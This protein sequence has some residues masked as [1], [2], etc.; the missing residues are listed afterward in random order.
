MNAR[1]RGA[2]APW[3][4]GW[5]ANLVAGVTPAC[6]REGRAHPA[7]AQD[8]HLTGP[9]P[10][11]E[12]AWS[13]ALLERATAIRTALASIEPLLRSLAQRQFEEGFAR[14]AAAEL[15]NDFGLKID[16]QELQ[17]D[18]SRPLS[19]GTLHARCVL[20]VFAQLVERDFDRNLARLAH[21]SES[22]DAAELIARFGFHAIDITPCADGRLAGVVDYILRVPPQVVTHRKSYAGAMFD[23][24]ETLRHWEAVEV[25]RW[26]EG[27]PNPAQDPTRY[28]K[29]GVYHFSSLDP[30]HEGCAAHGSDEGR[31]AGQLLQRLQ[32][33]EDAVHATHGAG[34]GVAILLVG[35]DTDTDAIKVHVPDAA[36]RC[37]L[38]RHVDAAS[39]YASTRSLSREAAKLAIKDAVA[40]CAGV[41][42]D[43][44]GT[45]GMRWLCGYLLKNNIAQID[46]V[47]REHGAA[48]ADRGHT[49]HLIVIGDGIDEVQLRN[50]AFQAQM[51]TVEEGAAD[52]EVGLRILR[53]LNAPRG[54]AVPVLAHF[55]Y[56][57]TIPGARDRAASRAQRL[58][59]AV[60]ARHAPACEQGTLVVRSAIH[61]RG[62]A[63][64]D[65]VTDRTTEACG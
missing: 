35:V 54:L 39:L 9:H 7:F 59:A 1:L 44:S 50:L 18:W 43:D 5:L 21:L 47:R 57:E 61:A 53:R 62:R 65:D 38:D 48:Y 27:R 26:R 15:Q 29:I 40:A 63:L 23:V 24:E 2:P 12:P 58:G 6:A 17:A 3:R 46:A 45:E 64:L 19:L 34:A 55:A 56:D 13:Q 25:R 32:Q 16:P 49:E 20:A 22:E 10:L 37:S 28:L 14:A 33:F 8:A 36:G 60:C 30:Q 4:D 41:A 42:L 51:D 11:A 31:A 52:L